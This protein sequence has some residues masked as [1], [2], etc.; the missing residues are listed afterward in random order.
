[1]I[2]PRSTFHLL[3]VAT[4]CVACPQS[5]WAQASGGPYTLRQGVLSSAGARVETAQFGATVTAGQP[6]AG[7]VSAGRFRLFG[8]FHHPDALPASLFRDGF[9]SAAFPAPTAL[10][11]DSTRKTP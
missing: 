2:A 6:A 10:T 3:V 7:V 8:G 5:L 4:L 9:E 11:V 1:M